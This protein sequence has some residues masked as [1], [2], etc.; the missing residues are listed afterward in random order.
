MENNLVK[1]NC[2]HCK[3]PLAFYRPDKGDMVQMT[4]PACHKTVRVKI[5][6]KPIRLNQQEEK[7]SEPTVRYIAQLVVV[8]GPQNPRPVYRLRI[9]SNIVG[10]MDTDTVQDIAISG[11][12]TI[13]RRS[14]DIVVKRENGVY[15]YL[16]TVINAKN[17][18]L[19]GD[20][21]LK[22]GDS[23]VLH[24]GDTIT[25]GMTKIRLQK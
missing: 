1:F 16:L 14:I 3:Q 25:L 6:E 5:Q 22:V 4:C 8:D 12:T 23:S 10:R 19:V 21:V 13:S 24:I 7:K 11:D 20:S 9:G 17:P 15:T 18:V 2:P